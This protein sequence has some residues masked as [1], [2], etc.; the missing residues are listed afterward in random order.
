[1]NNNF[2]AYQQ[3][4]Q[5]KLDEVNARLDLLRAQAK[6]KGADARIAL[7]RQIVELEKQQDALSERLGE[8]RD[9]GAEVAE[10]LG[11][12]INDAIEKAGKAL[13]GLFE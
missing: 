13:E 7:D 11:E 10:D 12:R 4:A 5:A 9:A 1:M 2:E 8:L 6:D 3:K